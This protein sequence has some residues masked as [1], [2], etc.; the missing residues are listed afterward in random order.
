MEVK[1]NERILDVG[2]GWG[3]IA[4]Y[5]SRKTNSVVE[6]V[7]LA[8]EQERY[9]VKTYP[10]VRVYNMDYKDLP[11]TLYG[12]YDKIYS[13]GM[14]EHVRYSNYKLFFEK[15]SKLLKA[16]GRFVLHTITYADSALNYSTRNCQ[17]DTF[18]TKYIF[19]GG[20][21]PKR[22]WIMESSKE[23]DLKMTHMEVF[24]GQH[25]GKTLRQWKRNFLDNKDS[26]KRM[27]YSD[28]VIRMYEYYFTEC[29][30]S[31]FTENIE[32]TQFVFEKIEGLEHA[33]SAF[34]CNR[35]K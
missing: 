25:Y 13:I 30:A 17:N 24:P 11:E 28:E 7:T 1:G 21:I 5:I 27:G 18:I 3:S 8:D 2:C 4:N 20:Q 31:F 22:E 14:F 6:G 35:K 23:T 10:N 16:S 15:M 26:V 29:E 33:Y 19:P 9:I 34:Q 12:S 32:I